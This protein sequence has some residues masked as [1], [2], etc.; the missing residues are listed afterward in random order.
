MKFLATTYKPF[1]GTLY[2][3]CFNGDTKTTI[4]NMPKLSEPYK[5]GILVW[6]TPIFII[7][8]SERKFHVLHVRDGDHHRHR[9]GGGGDGDAADQENFF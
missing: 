2:T 8:S 7:P 5:L 1:L 9:P 3:F 6:G 4:R